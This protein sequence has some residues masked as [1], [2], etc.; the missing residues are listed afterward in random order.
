MPWISSMK[1][2]P[3]IQPPAHLAKQINWK[4]PSNPPLLD[5][6]LQWV[7]WVEF[8]SQLPPYMEWGSQCETSILHWEPEFLFV[9]WGI[10]TGQKLRHQLSNTEGALHLEKQSV[11]TWSLLKYMHGNTKSVTCIHN[12]WP[13]IISGF[14]CEVYSN[15]SG[16]LLV[17]W[18]STWGYRA[19]WERS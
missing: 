2:S 1:Q 15:D 10:K 9:V 19:P 7:I 8:I 6:V 18:N 14:M 3:L 17:I 5:L 4:Q 12:L 16:C 13:A 11:I